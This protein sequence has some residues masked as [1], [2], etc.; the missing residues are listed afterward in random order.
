[1]FFFFYGQ[2]ILN[3]LLSKSSAKF[4]RSI[5]F[6]KSCASSKKLALWAIFCTK[7]C[8]CVIHRMIKGTAELWSTL[9]QIYDSDQESGNAKIKMS[10]SL[11]CACPVKTLEYRPHPHKDIKNISVN[12]DHGRNVCTRLDHRHCEMEE[13]VQH[14]CMCWFFVCNLA[15]CAGWIF[16][17]C[18]GWLCVGWLCVG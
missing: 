7:I 4:N 15:I 9:Q 12:R 16:S 13:K 3:S 2:I 6:L 1:M 18:V 17:L 14:A 10:K 11:T 8:K 5:F